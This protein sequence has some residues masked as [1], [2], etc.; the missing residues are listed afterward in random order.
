MSTRGGRVKNLV[1]KTFTR[2]TVIER[3]GSHKRGGALW[4]CQCEC[5]NLTTLVTKLLTSGHTQSCGCLKS[6]AARKRMTRHGH[7]SWKRGATKEYSTW[8]NMLKRCRDA[9]STYY[10]CY[11]GRGITV[12]KRW[13]IFENFYA[14]MGDKPPGSTIERIDNDGNY[15]PGNCRWATQAEQSMNRRVTVYLELNGLR[16]TMVEWAK[17]LQMK[18]GTLN[19]RHFR[20]LSTKEILRP[21]NGTNQYG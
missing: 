6:D 18:Y 2:L 13:E 10:Y 4:L 15:E 20:G 19:M 9:K 1:G 11:G 3:Q 16:L 12:C 17:K 8:L 21:F 14:D 5:G 7:T